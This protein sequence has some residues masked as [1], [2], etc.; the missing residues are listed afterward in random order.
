MPGGPWY[1]G[2]KLKIQV[3]SPLEYVLDEDEDDPDE[4]N[5]KYLY[6]A[7]AIPLMHNTLVE[8]LKSAGVDNLQLYSAR[9]ID[10]HNGQV[11]LD[12]QAFNVIGLLSASDLEASTWMDETESPSV[13]DTDVDSLVVDED[14]TKGFH[15]F[16][17]AENCS[18]ICVSEKV[19]RA[20]EE[21]RIPGIVFYGLEEWS[22]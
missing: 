14:K 22:G 4:C 12:Y 15:L 8:T 21:R 7:E 18:A 6:D 2:K 10:P 5:L 20:I 19:K 16:R 1:N 9:I 11:Y 3:P 13:L 17:L